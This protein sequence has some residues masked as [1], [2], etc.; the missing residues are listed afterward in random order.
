MAC[1]DRIVPSVAMLASRKFG[2]APWVTKMN[3][4]ALQKAEYEIRTEMGMLPSGYSHERA[5]PVYGTGQG[6]SN[7]SAIWFFCRVSFLTATNN[8]LILLR[9]PL[10]RA[11]RPFHSD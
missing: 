11:T 10:Q 6:S 5:H 8:E 1:Y 9:I 2:V 4:T 7:S 3:A